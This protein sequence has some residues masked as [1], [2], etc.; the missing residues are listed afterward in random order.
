MPPDDSSPHGREIMHVPPERAKFPQPKPGEEDHEQVHGNP[1][2]EP[3]D[4]G[5]PSRRP[6]L[7]E[8]PE[9]MAVDIEDEEADPVVDSGP[10]IDDGVK[11]LKKQKG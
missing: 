5:D 3:G 7:P 1:G 4:E 8:H 9:W 11:S 2:D 10:G 6:A